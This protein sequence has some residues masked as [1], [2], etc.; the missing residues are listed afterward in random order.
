MEIALLRLLKVILLLIF[1]GR[2]PY[3]FLTETL[4]FH[5]LDTQMCLSYP[6]G[7]FSSRMP[8]KLSADQNTAAQAHWIYS[9]VPH[10]WGTSVYTCENRCN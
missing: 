9:R 5:L 6:Q 8:G 7:D 10:D 4:D 2:C 1:C 3:F